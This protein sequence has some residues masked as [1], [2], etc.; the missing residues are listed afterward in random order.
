MGPFLGIL[1]PL[2]MP[3]LLQLPI[4]KAHNTR[5]NTRDLP[6]DLTGF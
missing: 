5:K 4:K 6:K 3:V 2:W 1:F